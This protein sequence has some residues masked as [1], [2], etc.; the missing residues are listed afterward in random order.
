M[1]PNYMLIITVLPLK[2]LSEEA[3]LLHQNREYLFQFLT[4]TITITMIILLVRL[5]Q[6]KNFNR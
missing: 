3:I 6:L 5:L 1:F 2:V 4:A